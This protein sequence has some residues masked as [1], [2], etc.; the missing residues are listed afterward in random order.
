MVYLLLAAGLFGEIGY[1]QVC[2]R[3]IA[4]LAVARR[5]SALAAARRRIGV[6]P[7]PA[8][9]QLLAGPAP[10]A[11]RAPRGLGSGVIPA[12]APPCPTSSRDLRGGGHHAARRATSP[13]PGGASGLD[14]RQTAVD[15]G[16]G[17]GRASHPASRD[18]VRSASRRGATPAPEAD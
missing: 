16:H 14:S 6:A 8:L 10:A 2:A 1:E 11:S 18:S 3:M 13:Y 12:S 7:L 5:P 4:G 15:T 17:E 9:F